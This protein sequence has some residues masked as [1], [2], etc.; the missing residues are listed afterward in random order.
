V[1]GA[2]NAQLGGWPRVRI[3]PLFGRWGYFV[4]PWLFACFPVRPKDTDLWIRLPTEDQQRALASAGITPH[5]R[6]AGRG[7]VE[8]QV[9]TPRDVPRAVRWLRRGYAAAVNAVEREE[10]EEREERQRR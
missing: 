1:A 8:C 9:V 5:R 7:W 10:R 4:G 6:F 3:A 2:L